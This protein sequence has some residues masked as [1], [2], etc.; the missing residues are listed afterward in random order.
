MEPTQDYTF[1]VLI[2]ILILLQIL[3]KLFPKS[4]KFCTNF[5]KY[6]KLEVD[7]SEE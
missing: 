6:I 3:Y 4:E 7:E 1:F 2:L 5:G